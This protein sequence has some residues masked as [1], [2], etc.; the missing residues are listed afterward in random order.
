[1]QAAVARLASRSDECLHGRKGTGSDPGGGR[2]DPSIVFGRPALLSTAKGYTGQGAGRRR[3]GNE[4]MRQKA[5]VTLPVPQAFAA[6]GGI[7]P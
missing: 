7:A 2:G 4:T 5:V 6:D 1:M 3:D